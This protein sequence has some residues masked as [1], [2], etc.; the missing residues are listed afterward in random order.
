MTAAENAYWDVVNAR[1]NLRVQEESL[2]LADA[3]L[4]RAQKEIELGATSKLEVF[5]PQANRANAELGVIQARY[6][7][8]QGED[9]LRRQMGADLDPA[10]RK[11]PLV[12]TESVEMPAESQPI[13]RDAAVEAALRHRPDLQSVMQNL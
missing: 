9:A 13:D 2:K 11:M 5:Q 10:Y 12:L 8:E 3:A 4:T 7:L 6:R 1:E